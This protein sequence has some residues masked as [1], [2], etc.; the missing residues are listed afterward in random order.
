MSTILIVEDEHEL[1]ALLQRQLEAEGYHAIV[2]HDGPLALTLAEQTQLD[3]VILDWMLPAMDGLTVCR[4]L[5]ERSIVPIIMLTARAEESDRVIGLEIGADDY[6]TKPFSLRELLARVRALL[7][8][9]ELLR[10][11]EHA[12]EE[13]P[14]ALGRLT[15]D[16]VARRVEVDKSPVDLTVKEYDLLLLLARHPSRSFSRAY[17]L[18]MVWGA[19]YDGGDRTVD[20]HIVRLRRKLGELGDRIETVWGVGYRYEV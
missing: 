17:L 1:A 9:V 18:D 4:R 20:T 5:R 11:A 8:R 16:P 2:A 13:A 12:D 3:L 19:N 10:P 6:L 15:I 14:I 7:R